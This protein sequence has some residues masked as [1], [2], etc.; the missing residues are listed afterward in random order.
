[1]KSCWHAR[2]VALPPSL[3]RIVAEVVCT[4]SAA[5]PHSSYA[6]PKRPSTSATTSSIFGSGSRPFS[7]SCQ[8]LGP[9]KR[10]QKGTK[11]PMRTPLKAS[12]PAKPGKPV[13]VK[14]VS[15]KPA[16]A[17]KAA[18][19]KPPPKAAVPRTTPKAKDR[20]SDRRL[21]GPTT[22]SNYIRSLSYLPP[23]ITLTPLA[24]QEPGAQANAVRIAETPSPLALNKATSL[25]VRPAPQ[26]LYSAP[27]FLNLP[28]NTK[29]PEI[30]IL[31]RSNVGKSTLLNA[32]AGLET[33][34]Q[35]GHSHGASTGRKGLAITSAKA[36]CTKMLNGYGFGPP[37][38][39][40][41]A[42]TFPRIEQEKEEEA[43]KDSE[44]AAGTTRGA[45]IS[46]SE[47]RSKRPGEP[48]PAYSF[49]MVDM[50]GYGF[51]SRSEWGV[52]ITK[53]LERRST[54]CGAVLL[55]DAL[56]GLKDGDRQALNMLRDANVKTTIVLTKADKLLPPKVL[57][58]PR[59]STVEVNE[60]PEEIDDEPPFMTDPESKGE[61][62]LRESCIHVWEI[63]KKTERA[64]YGAVPWMEGQG[65]SPEIC[66][67]GAGDPKGGGFGVAGARLA[68]CRMAGLITPEQE[69]K[70]VKP[71][72]IV[73][74]H[75]HKPKKL[76]GAKAYSQ[77]PVPQQGNVVVPFDQIQ[78]SE[79]ATEAAIDQ[80]AELRYIAD[81]QAARDARK[82]RIAVM[83]AE[84][85]SRKA[86]GLRRSA[87]TDPIGSAIGQAEGASTARS[88]RAGGR[89]RTWKRP[90]S[91][92]ERVVE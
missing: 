84:Q 49:V 24:E 90:S 87:D 73:K 15:V 14:P 71:K 51:M 40:S 62:T 3:R 37:L 88:R 31:G 58:P 46:R 65:W 70:L 57:R 12:K 35:A 36:G 29:M 79:T 22:Q 9:V 61:Q 82:E 64:G 10:L 53:Y 74:K 2:Y 69:A 34:G 8:R 92:A 16:S 41:F 30:C 63:L 11:P 86:A 67:T 52:E 72:D 66:V 18:A 81:Q 78:W 39:P 27:R 42:Q 50:P 44:A 75:P 38:K 6:P 68:I 48:T 33:G 54:L 85:A 7:S 56:T 23:P 20:V 17:K 26:F 32:L 83:Q 77:S 43:E 21:P 5:S 13:G 60:D 91:R 59:A 55:V 89:Q 19:P 4:Q 76:I 47:K 1:M 80:T 45:V 28:V 25:F